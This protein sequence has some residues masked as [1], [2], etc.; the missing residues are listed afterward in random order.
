MVLALVLMLVSEGEVMVVA[1][2][3]VVVRG[4]SGCGGSAFVGGRA[5]PMNSLV[6]S[7]AAG[8]C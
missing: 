1:V 4:G 8:L 3:V 6:S 5:G 7:S 2:V